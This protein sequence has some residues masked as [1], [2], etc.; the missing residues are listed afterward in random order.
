METH[1]AN[2]LYLALLVG[3]CIKVRYTLVC[4]MP[5]LKIGKIENGE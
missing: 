4:I 5:G 1:T 3:G 2:Y